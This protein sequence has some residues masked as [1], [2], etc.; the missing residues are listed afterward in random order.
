M[1]NNFPISGYVAK[2]SSPSSQD[3]R[4]ELIH[5]SKDDVE[6][7]YEEDVLSGS[8]TLERVE[9][10]YNQLVNETI[11]ENDIDFEYSSVCGRYFSSWDD[12]DELCLNKE[13]LQLDTEYDVRDIGA[14]HGQIAIYTHDEEIEYETVEQ[15]MLQVKEIID[16]ADIPFLK[17]SVTLEEPLDDEDNTVGND[18]MEFYGV[19]YEK[20]EE[21]GLLQYLKEN[22][23]T[24]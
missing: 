11:E 4:F 9:D 19:P 2:T 6:D 15:I 5:I 13:D 10:E 7:T 20:I 14:K 12:S 21:D 24:P 16:G 23:D 3:T 18:R 22:E 17:M 8:N 1:F